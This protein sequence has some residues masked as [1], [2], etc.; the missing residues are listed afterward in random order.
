MTLRSEGAP[1]LRPE[2]GR[3][4]ASS[5]P[6]P[7]EP[8]S[9]QRGGGTERSKCVSGRT[10]ARA[11]GARP[12]STSPHPTQDLEVSLPDW[13][14][15]PSP[16]QSS[17][18]D[19]AA[20]EAS[21]LISPDQP[22]GSDRLQLLGESMLRM[23]G[24]LCRARESC[25]GTREAEM[26]SKELDL[27]AREREAATSEEE[28]RSR[29]LDLR[30]REQEAREACAVAEAREREA[31][32]VLAT[33]EVRE[34][35]AREAIAVAETRERETAESLASLEVRA[36]EAKERAAAGED[37]LRLQRLELATR[38]KELAGRERRLAEREADLHS[39]LSA[40]E[41]KLLEWERR[42]VEREARSAEVD[43]AEVKLREDETRVAAKQREEEER[44]RESR[45]QLD[46]QYLRWAEAVKDAQ[47]LKQHMP[48][49]RFSPRNGKE[50]Q[51]LV[52]QMEE[53]Q[54]RIHAIKRGAGSWGQTPTGTPISAADSS[55][56]GGS[57]YPNAQRT[58]DAPHHAA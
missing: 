10:S 3:R 34:Y 45:R 44:L 27:K 52:R 24:E 32:E 57:G 26:S 13:S 41:Q 5:Q 55:S 25:L 7:H 50:N 43:Q 37:A 18:R 14:A 39:D 56:T 46:E 12:P 35:E 17:R 21:L 9:P 2:S 6:P 4:L 49:P 20:E 15:A 54:N 51:E 33:V 48:K 11:P 16:S 40:R 28:L 29:E 1:V 31:R 23:D 19:L 22:P 36:R 38:E 53:Q 58:D 47:V 42:L 30:V 8:G